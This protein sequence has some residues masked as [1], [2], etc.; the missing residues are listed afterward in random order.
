VTD[1]RAL[2]HHEQLAAIADPRRLGILRMLMARPA[3]LTQIG[4]RIGKHPAWVRHHVQALLAAGLIELVESRTVKNYTEKYYGATSGAFQT[5][6]LIVPDPGAPE[7]LVAL[8]S[9]GLGL[10]LL[11]HDVE[12][13]HVRFVSVAMGSLDGLVAL[14]QGLCDVAGSHLLDVDR[15]EYNT[16]FLRHLFPDV[17]VLALTLA[18]REQGLIV[19]PGNPFKLKAITDLARPDVTLANRNP[20][21]G[22]RVWLDAQIALAGMDPAEITGYDTSYDTHTSVASAISTGTA[23]VGIGLRAAADAAGLA[24]QPLFMERYDLVMRKDRLSDEAIDAV[25]DSLSSRRLKRSLGTL[26]GYDTLHTGEEAAG[27]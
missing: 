16:P 13:A 9:H 8:G 6:L 21:S 14:R 2:N 7:T 15:D 27:R 5:H 10:E 22:T 24:F 26:S 25:L 4:E 3:T 1:I 11:G 19:A 18:Y 20:G 12:H 17:P 23:D